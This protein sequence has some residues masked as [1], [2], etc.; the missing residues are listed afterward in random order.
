MASGGREREMERAT[1]ANRGGKK[2]KKKKEK[3]GRK[4]KCH[5]VIGQRSIAIPGRNGPDADACNVQP[6]EPE[7]E[8]GT[9]SL[10]VVISG[11]IFYSIRIYP[12]S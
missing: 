7:E 5:R 1:D 10:A 8:E 3:E 4:V 6:A 11:Y 12:P 2:K 9:S